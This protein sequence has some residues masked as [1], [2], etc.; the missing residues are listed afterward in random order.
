MILDNYESRTEYRAW[1]WTSPTFNDAFHISQSELYLLFQ[2]DALQSTEA[3][4]YPGLLSHVSQ[5]F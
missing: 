1:D 2:H 3:K 5:C 4:L